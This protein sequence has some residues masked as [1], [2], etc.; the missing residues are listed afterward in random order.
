[1]TA[2]YSFLVVIILALVLAAF[3][4]V[5]FATPVSMAYQHDSEALAAAVKCPI[6]YTVRYGETLYSVATRCGVSVVT[7]MRVNALRT[8]RVWPG[9]R[10]Y[11][12]TI[13]IRSAPPLTSSIHRA[14][15]P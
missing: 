11:I 9:Q 12:P 14:P 13:K 7:L 6:I 4:A 8:T 1:M 15:A 2:K 5:C 10:I 3:P